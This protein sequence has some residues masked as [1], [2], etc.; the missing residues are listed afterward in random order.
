MIFD[1]SFSCVCFKYLSAIFLSNSPGRKPIG[2]TAT[3]ELHELA[4]KKGVRIE[5]KVI[6]ISSINTG[7]TNVMPRSIMIIIVSVSGAVQF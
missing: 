3:S 6:Q 5:F 7:M 4:V 2:V 1:K